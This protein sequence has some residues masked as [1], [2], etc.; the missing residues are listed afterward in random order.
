AGRGPDPVHLRPPDPAR[1]AGGRTGR[2]SPRPRRRVCA[3]HGA[4]DE[5]RRTGDDPRPRP[6]RPPAPALG[7]RPPGWDRAPRRIR[8]LPDVGP[9]PD[10]AGRRRP[11]GAVI[12]RTPE[13]K[14]LAA[15]LPSA[16]R[17]VT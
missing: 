10:V 4:R 6:P 2:V 11:P 3:R 7:A 17:C 12:G 16:S 8:R 9:R 14:P 13:R 5:Q 1:L 15:L